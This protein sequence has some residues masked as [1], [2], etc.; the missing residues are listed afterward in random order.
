[1]IDAKATNEFFSV[2]HHHEERDGAKDTD[3]VP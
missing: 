2:G 1:M 3:P